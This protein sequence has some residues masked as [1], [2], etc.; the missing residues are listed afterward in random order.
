MLKN[1]KYYMRLPQGWWKFVAVFFIA[2][3]VLHFSH[4]TDLKIVNESG[5]QLR[6]TD[7]TES[8]YHLGIINAVAYEIPPAF[9]YASGYKLSEYHI[10]MH[11]LAVIFCEYLGIDPAI[12]TYYFLPL[13]LL[14]MILA[15]PAVFFYELHGDTNVSILLGL[16]MLGSDFSFIPALISINDIPQNFPWTLTF[17][18][19]IWSLFTLNG[20]MMAIPLFFG[21]ALAFQRYFSSHN[22]RHLLVFALFTIAAYRVKSSMGIQVAC[23]S[24]A[25]LAT[26]EWQSHLKVWR[27]ALPVL[28][29]MTGLIFL[30]LYIKSFSVGIHYVLRWDMFNGLIQSVKFLGI[31]Q[32]ENAVSNPLKHPFQLLYILILYFIGFMGI[33]LIFLKYFYDVVKHTKSTKPII[34]FFLYFI[35]VGIIL[36]EIIYLG[37]KYDNINNGVWFKIQS[38]VAATYFITAYIVSLKKIRHKIIA[39]LVVIV[40]SYP[41]TINFLKLRYDKEYMTISA[42]AIFALDHLRKSVPGNAVI[43]GYP[44]DDIVLFPFFTGRSALIVNLAHIEAIVEPSIKTERLIDLKRF[45][46]IDN[47]VNRKKILEKYNVEYLI[48]PSLLSG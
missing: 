8:I 39:V 15:V 41:S 28:L 40:L 25:T 47:E 12:M 2:L 13:L 36:S 10:D 7:Y 44:N 43:M 14:G 26:L 42:N 34:P 3:T 48:I 30:D 5:Y 22:I 11:V 17:C 38:I 9:P 4:F 18:T 35:I 45:F 19:T 21:S 37:G 6:T 16:L 27:K 20:I 32:W 29:F 33:R 23:V 31:E 46:M 1:I 24:F